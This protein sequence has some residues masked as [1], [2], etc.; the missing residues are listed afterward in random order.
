MSYPK[1]YASRGEAFIGKCKEDFYEL[2]SFRRPRAGL[3]RIGEEHYESTVP[4]VGIKELNRAI[5]LYSNHRTTDIRQVTCT[6][7]R[8]A[9][10]AVVL[11]WEDKEL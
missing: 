9:I 6:H 2:L 11:N 1:H 3:I 8:R 5:N 10:Q 4:N 7:C